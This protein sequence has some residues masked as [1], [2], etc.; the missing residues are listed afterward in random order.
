MK[1]IIL[2]EW[3]PFK[4][5]WS[6]YCMCIAFFALGLFTAKGANFPF[7]DVYKNAPYIISFVI[8]LFSQI[9]IFSVAILAAQILLKERDANFHQILYATPVQKN[10]LLLSR[11][12][13]IAGIAALLFLLLVV[14]FMTGHLLPWI[15]KEQLTS[16]DSWHY[17]Q[18]FLL[19]GLPNTLLCS[20]I[21]CM[22]GWLSKNKLLIYLS[23]LSIYVLYIII[24]IF[25]N[26]PLMATASPVSN[27]AMSVAAKIDPF[28]LSALFEQTKYWS[29]LERNT[30]LAG[31]HG[32]L[33]QNRIIWLLASLVFLITGINT[34][35][36]TINEKRK[37][38][39]L[40]PAPQTGKYQ[41][42]LVKPGP[43]TRKH[44][45]QT[46]FSFI[47]TD[48][49]IVLKGIPFVLLC[50]I[51]IFLLGM[52][53]YGTIEAGIRLPQ[54]FATTGLMVNTILK[55]APFFFL[56][57]ILFYSHEL[58]WRSRNANM[59]PL[60]NST[61]VNDRMIIISKFISLSFIPFILTLLSIVTGII[62]QL[63][64]EYP[65]IDFLL[66]ISLF[67]LLMLPLIC[68]L[69]IV[70]G[71]QYLFNNKY[72]GII[73]AALFVLI[74]NTSL[75][76]MIGLKNPLFRIGN[77]Y[78]HAYSEMSGWGDYFNSYSWT[79][80]YAMAFAISFSFFA[81]VIREKVARRRFSFSTKR[82]L[83]LCLFVLGGAASYIFYQ[84]NILHQK[85]NNSE[86]TDWKQA[87]ET[88]YRKYENMPQPVIYK[89]ETSIDL[90][91]HQQRYEVTGRYWL[92][93]KTATAIDS[94]LFYF[95]KECVLE[96]LTVDGA[97]L[98]A[99]DE[100]FG[101][102]LFRFN[103]PLLPQD[104]FKIDFRFNYEWSGFKGHA[105]FNAIVDNGSF[106]RIS[107]YFPASG[108]Q[109]DNEIEDENLRKERGLGNATQLPEPEDS[110]AGHHFIDLNMQLST[111]AGQTAIGVG[112][113]VKQWQ[114]NGRNYFSYSSGQPIPFRFAVAS[115]KYATKKET[116]RGR[117]LEIYYH[118]AH[119][120]NID[121]L[122]AGAK[123]TLD[124]CE[125]NFA[126]YPF[127][128]IRFAEIASFT[129][130]FAGTA[131]P[132]SVFMPEDMVFHTNIK[133][134]RIANVIGELT[135]H[136]LAHQWWGGN[137]LQPAYRKGR[138]VLTESL[139]MYT[140]LMLNKS[141][142]NHETIIGL[143]KMYKDMYFSE[144]A[145]SNEVPLYK[146]GSGETHL[147]YYKGVVIM[148]QL[149]LLLGEQKLNL[150]LKQLLQN[151]RYPQQPASTTDL[152]NEL[153]AVSNIQQYARI[154][155]LFKKIITH[156]VKINKATV[157]PASNGQY[158]LYVDATVVKY[159]L[160]NGKKNPLPVTGTVDVAVYTANT[161]KIYSF[162][163][164]NNRLS[165]KLSVTTKPSKVEIDPDIKL[166]D[167]F[168]EDN[169][170]ELK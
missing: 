28:G 4:K 21:I 25:S 119:A 3:L 77:S 103:K 70:T 113:L 157:N 106:I 30:Q 1:Q 167:A 144:R 153:H 43:E 20:A 102:R 138:A 131:Y 68:C 122:V 156:D 133:K 44:F 104:S 93:N 52:E 48:M 127:R 134:S 143:I 14:G 81:F 163:V 170:K 137:M 45:I 12:L 85:Q 152:I 36:F 34:F 69:V 83:T 129:K 74:T 95:N 53:I 54:R 97:R 67:Y 19:F 86:K 169:I 40:L 159:D 139:A 162:A 100:K 42:R 10:T 24:S 165:A 49:K 31:L 57:A 56:M 108:Y 9:S 149:Q 99:Q 89:V 154:D 117:K 79:M 6:F 101:H 29:P 61:A 112:E 72:A 5:K 58:V 38:K 105:S 66:Y 160:I 136:E 124:Y 92:K 37:Q 41:L 115:A 130:G 155:E 64:Y 116:Y 13:L 132:A 17:L 76:Q 16:F 114:Q 111:V 148:Y 150:A 125:Q 107:N 126:P 46:V 140:E 88:N 128:T 18:P 118:A 166:M 110:P 32:S 109:P 11:F 145:F 87:Y 62:F 2:F 71:I 158:E 15:N 22:A 164:I 135:A 146:A 33:L 23:A 26:S 73:A 65:S 121:T 60:E 91:P 8:A 63:L 123:R 147:N 47:K 59:H 168:D 75:G 50:L 120:E 35:R 94:F 84:N 151:H 161:K 51:W 82:W 141:I 7:P 98:S 80:L 90:F 55:T 78:G 39:E 96:S 27:E 142:A